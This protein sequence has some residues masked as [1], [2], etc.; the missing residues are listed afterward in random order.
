MK[1]GTAAWRNHFCSRQYSIAKRNLRNLRILIL[2][3]EGVLQTRA[4]FQ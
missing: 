2:I 1:L 4:A 3:F